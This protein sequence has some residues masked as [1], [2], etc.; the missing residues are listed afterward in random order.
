MHGRV[1]AW[2][3]AAALCGCEPPPPRQLL[4][5][6]TLQLQRRQLAAVAAEAQLLAAEIA[7]GHLGRSY[8]WVQQQ[9]LAEEA[10]RA[11]S[12]L[13]R[14]APPHLQPGQQEALRLAGELRL[15]VGHIAAAQDDPAALAEL[16]Q[17]LDGLR[18]RAQSGSGSTR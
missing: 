2:L 16:R 14:P 4:D 7:A 3:L 15:A 8:A 9:S 5:G 12:E 11:G 18:G 6:E 17:A 13:T 1:F 10:G